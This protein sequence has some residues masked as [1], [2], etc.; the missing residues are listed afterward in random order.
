M[1]TATSRAAVG[2]LLLLAACGGDSGGITPPPPPPPPAVDHV[3]VQQTSGTIKAGATLQLLATAFESNGN[4]IAGTTIV[5]SSSNPALASVTASGLLIGLDTGGPVTITASTGGKSDNTVVNVIPALVTSA[6]LKPDTA[7]MVP[8]GTRKMQLI[9][10]DEF[11]FSVTNRPVT[12][13]SF[14]PDAATVDGTGVVTAVAI[15]E[16]TIFATVGGRTAQALVRVTATSLERFRIEVTNSLAYRVDVLQ[17]GVI[18]GSVDGQSSSTIERPLTPTFTMS[19]RMPPPNGH[20][21]TLTES[22]PAVLNP[23]GSIPLVID[24]VMNDGRIY[25]NPVLRNLTQKKVIADFPDQGA[26]PKCTCSIATGGSVQ[27]YG[28]W[29]WSSLASLRVYGEFD[30]AF[31]GPFLSFLV[32]LA[33]LEANSGAWR[34]DLLTTP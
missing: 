20:G 18:V 19:W 7:L 6:S 3:V 14:N 25:F 21:E 9:A 13:S 22:Y 17:N 12:W 5:W 27:Q 30:A 10:T 11:G 15:G 26:I 32:P 29:L 8:G 24:N 4:A 34:F 1:S 23:T 33:Q 16:A 2:V 31:N 28:Y